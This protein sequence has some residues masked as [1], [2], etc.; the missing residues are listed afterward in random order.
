MHAAA[1][2]EGGSLGGDKMPRPAWEKEL[3]KS[4]LSDEAKRKGNMPMLTD[5]GPPRP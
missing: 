5:K 3:R 2:R 4:T 1:I